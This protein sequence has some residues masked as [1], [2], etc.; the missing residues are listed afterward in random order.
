ML[1]FCLAVVLMCSMGTARADFVKTYTMPWYTD[2]N[3][4]ADGNGNAWTTYQ[5]DSD[6]SGLTSATNWLPMT[7]NNGT[8]FGPSQVYGHPAYYS[9]QSLTWGGWDGG[10]YRNTGLSFTAGTAGEYSW[11]GTFAPWDSDGRATTLGFAKYD[12]TQ[13]TSLYSCNVASGSSINLAG[14]PELQN[15]P[16]T[17][18]Q[19]LV[20]AIAQPGYWGWGNAT[21]NSIGF[22]YS[23]PEPLTIGFLTMGSL[24]LR[25]R[26]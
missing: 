5:I 4:H 20:L 14:I 6:T 25:R 8:W 19:M 9:S 24:M 16:V 3:P 15:I 12:G 11:I 23:V 7:W 1:K 22:G 26:K 13:Y 17:E 18:G 10:H 2:A 21:I